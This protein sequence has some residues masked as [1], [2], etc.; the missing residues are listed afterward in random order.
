MQP[1]EASATV[2]IVAV[3]ALAVDL[4]VLLAAT[5]DGWPLPVPP[6]VHL[7]VVAALAAWTYSSRTCRADLRLPLLLTV[8]TAFLGPFGAGG[9]LLMMVLVRVYGRA[10]ESFEVWYSALF[11]DQIDS[12]NELWQ[13]I[14]LSNTPDSGR[15]GVT[16][17]SDILFFGSLAQKQELISLIS[18]QF[19]PAVAPVLRLAIDDTNNGIRVQAAS[20]ITKIEDGFLPRTMELSAAVQ[21]HPTDARLL[22]KLAQLHDEYVSA[23]LLD[24]EREQ[25]SRRQALAAYADYLA[26]RPDDI[27]ARVSAGRLLVAGGRYEDAVEWLERALAQS[28]D[29]V[30]LRLLYMEALFH[31]NRLS[32]LRRVAT[33]SQDAC[34]GDAVS[35]EA[36][37]TVKLWAGAA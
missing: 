29:S 17:F 6:A 30:P 1:I 34:G 22:L 10:T 9:V 36:H 13:S 23:G 32:D 35:L 20:A 21:E 37:E 27:D 33:S 12:P 18:K 14:L 11:P 19:R 24:A 5:I 31:L 25:E 16:P 2:V 26:L 7:L 4:A 28:A 8:M 15:V 3:A